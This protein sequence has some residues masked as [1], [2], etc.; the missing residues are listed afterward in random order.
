[1]V[2]VNPEILKW[3]RE[4]AGLELHE[5][6]KKLGFQDSKKSTAVDKLA[7]LE[8]GGDKEPT[9]NQLYKMTTVYHQPLLVFYLSEPPKKGER[10]E[11]FR[12]LPQKTADRKGNARLDLLMRDVKAGQNLVRNLLEEENA[13]PLPFIG[14]ASISLDYHDLAEEIMKTLD[15]DLAVFRDKSTVRDAFAYLRERIE[16]KGIFVLLRS[17][18]GS[19]HTTIP[20]EVFRGCAF[21][22]PLAPFIVIN[23]QDT[24][25]AWSF[26]ALHEAAHLWLGTSGVSGLW[27]D[28]QIE[29]FCNRVAG[30]ILLPMDELRNAEF[31]F[32]KGFDEIKDQID[33]FAD[34][35]NVS[36]AMVYYSL[37]LNKR[38]S[39]EFW[40]LL[41][42][43]SKKDAHSQSERQDTSNNSPKGGPSYYVVRRHHLGSALIRLVKQYVDTGQLTPSK[44][45]VV[46]GVKP[47]NVYPL[48]NPDY[49]AARN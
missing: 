46:L 28:S 25:A 27:G 1:M 43:Q 33:A 5:A 35:R 13:E 16:R 4:T 47:I 22:D 26:T 19:Y 20:V 44:A 3:A 21:A 45:S 12:T 40:K 41:Q 37:L 11:D 9:R 15:F 14:S 39:Q 17:D 29:R 18:L 31:D 48:L 34:S 10:G 42:D 38:I 8:N 23:R 49:F 7:D 36:R 6:A 24:V 32:T 30:Q 2:A